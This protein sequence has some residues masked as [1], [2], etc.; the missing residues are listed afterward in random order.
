M[1]DYPDTRSGIQTPTPNIRP[2]PGLGPNL[3]PNPGMSPPSNTVTVSQRSTFGPAI[4]AAAVVIVV[5]LVAWNVLGDNDVSTAPVPASETTAPVAPATPDAATDTS[6]GVVPTPTP[7][8]VAPE[9]AP[10]PVPDTSPGIVPEGDPATDLPPVGDPPAAPS[11]G[12]TTAP[13]N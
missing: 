12:T 2:T 7:P 1:A 5:G 13:S 8:E 4:A 6:P 11:T 10:A 9:P 3:G